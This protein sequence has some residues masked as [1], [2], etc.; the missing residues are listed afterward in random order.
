MTL[1]KAGVEPLR[2]TQAACVR[3]RRIAQRSNRATCVYTMYEYRQATCCLVTSS[4]QHHHD[5]AT[6]EA[7]IYI[8]PVTYDEIGPPGYQFTREID[9]DSVTIESIIARGNSQSCQR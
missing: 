5:N 1:R 2:M 8:D 4:S 3:R 9:P 6:A 7:S